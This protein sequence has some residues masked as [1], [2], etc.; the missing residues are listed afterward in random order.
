MI[1]V[2]NI[3]DYINTGKTLTDEID[4]ELDQPFLNYTSFHELERQNPNFD[5]F[6]IND[7]CL[8]HTTDYFPFNQT[9]SSSYDKRVHKENKNGKWYDQRKTIHF[10][11]N[12]L[13]SDHPGNNFRGRKYVV[14]EPLKYQINNMYAIRPEDSWTTS[15]VT[16][17][18]K[19]IVLVD[20][21]AKNE[22][23]GVDL[24][25]YNIIYFS[26]DIKVA[27]ERVLNAIGYK[28][29]NIGMHS[30][31][32]TSVL[33]QELNDKIVEKYILK[34][35]PHIFQ[36][37]HSESYYEKVEAFY[38]NRDQYLSKYDGKL[39]DTIDGY[40]LS[41][42]E[43]LF[44]IQEALK[45][46][47]FDF[48]NFSNFM[49]V[50]GIVYDDNTKQFSCMDEN[51][52][53]K[54]FEAADEV[55][56]TKKY[57]PYYNPT[58]GVYDYDFFTDVKK[59]VIE[60]NKIMYQQAFNR[61]NELIMK[62]SNEVEQESEEEKRAKEFRDRC[63]Y[64]FLNQAQDKRLDEYDV[65]ELNEFLR[66]FVP[67]FGMDNYLEF[68]FNGNISTRTIDINFYDKKL[69]EDF[70]SFF[71]ENGINCDEYGTATIILN[72]S[73]KLDVFINSFTKLVE[74]LK[75]HLQEC[76][77]KETSVRSM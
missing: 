58:G 37:Q 72:N 63:Y 24:S 71:D 40:S 50:R 69:L 29:Q 32:K 17:S 55:T 74:D 1:V 64:N 70:K 8:V 7:L 73:M 52:L 22:L 65:H 11:L 2:I 61:V 10:C 35:Y 20:I 39:K 45:E 30:F 75:K 34:Y 53:L 6:S 49:F 23:S 16:L 42:E 26:G 33:D 13:V 76:S 60:S 9:I 4:Y 62:L 21:R 31:K 18:N 47:T 3:N 59:Q 15:S 44:L 36:G 68:Q 12:G 54:I 46:K 77:K 19:A 38:R 5:G 27:T 57:S 66:R 51:T 67:K 14:L 56:T 25:N 48:N 41:N 28:P 43:L